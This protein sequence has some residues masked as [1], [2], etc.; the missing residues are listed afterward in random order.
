MDILWL[1]IF[2][3]SIPGSAFLPED[4]SE[5]MLLMYL[6]LN[7]ALLFSS[8]GQFPVLKK[9]M[10]FLFSAILPP[11]RHF[12]AWRVYCLFSI[13]YCFNTLF[14][15]QHVL[16]LPCT[17]IPSCILSRASWWRCAQKK[18]NWAEKTKKPALKWFVWEQAGEMTK[19]QIK[20][21]IFE[22]KSL[23]TKTERKGT[24]AVVPHRVNNEVRLKQHGIKYSLHNTTLSSAL[25]RVW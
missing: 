8:Q 15:S 14:Y 4:F 6:S 20:D 5:V 22:N 24:H 11:A 19:E 21:N 23:L 16:K 7:K 2:R 17:D 18:D 25:N 13:F 12:L 1:H 10:L 3:Q 9:V